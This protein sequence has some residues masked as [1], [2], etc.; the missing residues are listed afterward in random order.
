MV[1]PED[2]MRELAVCESAEIV[3]KARE[4][5]NRSGIMLRAGHT[6]DLEVPGQQT[7][8]DASNV[9]GANG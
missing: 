8:Q 2:V 9:C 5:W 6:Y 4:Y 3:V 7:W 1:I